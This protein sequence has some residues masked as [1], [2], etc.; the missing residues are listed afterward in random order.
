MRAPT[1]SFMSLQRWA[2]SGFA[3][4]LLLHPAPAAARAGRSHA[5]TCE[6]PKKK[7]S[8]GKGSKKSDKSKSASQESTSSE[9]SSSSSSD[10]AIDDLGGLDDVAP[11][12]RRAE[13]VVKPEPIAPV[14]STREAPPVA[15]EPDDEPSRADDTGATQSDAE[16][17]AAGEGA[18][19]EAAPQSAAEADSGA[20]G[21]SVVIDAYA[22]FGIATRSVHMPSTMGA[23]NLAP[24]VAPAAEVGLRVTSHPN[25]PLSFYVHLI[26]QSAL[27]F[28]VTEH[29]PLALPKEVR[30]RSERVALEIAPRW[31]FVSSKLDLAIPLGA[32][33][34]TL[35]AE[36]H[37]SETPSFSLV[38]PHVRVEAAFSLGDRVS[39]KLSPELHYIIMVDQDLKTAG[40][41]SSGPAL[42]GDASVDARLSETWS[43]GINY[44]E[45]HAILAP[46]R[47]SVTFRD[48]ERYLTLR[49]VGSF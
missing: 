23:L 4:W 34:R 18:D 36:V 27:G 6:A 17:S 30:A 29:P 25:A 39:L 41:G 21:P 10:D 32:T 45:S 22:G 16:A 26:Y 11:A 3:C 47:G 5:R 20:N 19:A 43:T 9:S 7:K 40:V 46:A 14:K 37:T 48:V 24:G 35:W 33:I 2:A 42:G 15:T 28:S 44:R 8:A 31:H 1:A 12:P 49:V 38:G 13:P